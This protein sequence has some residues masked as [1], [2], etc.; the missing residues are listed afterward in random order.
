[1][2]RLNPTVSE[3]RALYSAIESSQALTLGSPPANEP[4][5]VARL[6]VHLTNQLNVIL[7]SR[8]HVLQSSAVFVHGR[9]QVTASTFPKPKPGS[10][11]IGDL[12]LLRTHVHRGIVTER[13]ARSEEH[14]SE[15]QS[16][17][18]LVCRLLL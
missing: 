5:L 13:R 11:E 14:T 10:V 1:M 8:G 4:T 12:L 2:A 9:P 16:R 18:H 17:G 15:L 3:F 6:A 7:L